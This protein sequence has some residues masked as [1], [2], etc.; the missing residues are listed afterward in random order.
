MTAR[1]PA[2][3]GAMAREVL[4]P[5]LRRSGYSTGRR[6]GG[7]VE[8]EKTVDTGRLTFGIHGGRWDEL[9]GDRLTVKFGGEVLDLV[10]VTF[11][12]HLPR[13]AHQEWQGV[14]RSV[15]DRALALGRSGAGGGADD[16]LVESRR[17]LLQQELEGLDAGYLDAFG[18]PWFDEQD[19]ATWLQ[20][21]EKHFAAGEA[22]A[23]ADARER[24]PE[25]LG[26][27]DPDGDPVEM[28][29]PMVLASREDIAEQLWRYAEED[30][31]VR[32]LDS[33]DVTWTQVM[34]AAAAPPAQIAQSGGGTVD[35]ALAHAAVEVLTG[36]A[37]P[38]ARKVRRP[39]E[40]VAAFWARVGPD[41]DQRSSADGPLGM[42]AQDVVRLT[43]PRPR[44]EGTG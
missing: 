21:I 24:R 42:P 26:P 3:V 22:A 17:L 35:A 14:A 1:K 41:R 20:F 15:F 27:A 2:G 10:Y 34:T 28:A 44:V 8:W 31:A 43:A 6:S 9:T 18:W 36:A 38:L 4:G 37:R 7:G 29:P 32:M 5:L 19:L 30:L 23:T 13:A 39:A 40:D 12:E 33:D 25:L 11:L 16:E